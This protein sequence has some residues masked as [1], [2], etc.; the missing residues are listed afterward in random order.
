MLKKIISCIALWLALSPL[1]SAQTLTRQNL[2]S[3]LGF[4]N[5]TRAGVFPVGWTGTGGL[6]DDQVMHSGK[7]SARIDRNTSSAGT[8]STLTGTIPLDFAGKTIEWR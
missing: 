5:N 2:A 7:Y 6:T 3:I 1:C 8:F 4:E